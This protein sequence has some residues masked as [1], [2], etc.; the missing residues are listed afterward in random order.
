[1]TNVFDPKS[2]IKG[3]IAEEIFRI[4][5]LGSDFIV[6]D[7]GIEDIAKR[8]IEE[9]TYMQLPYH[10]LPD[11]YVLFHKEKENFDKRTEQ[12]DLNLVE[13]KYVAASYSNDKSRLIANKYE[14]LWRYR[15][16]IFDTEEL[17]DLPKGK[18]F[19]NN[20]DRN[21]ENEL[22]S[23]KNSE[24]R[25]NIKALL[26]NLIHDKNKNLQDCINEPEFL[27]YLFINDVEKEDLE[28]YRKAWLE[29]FASFYSREEQDDIIEHYSSFDDDELPHIFVF[30]PRQFCWIPIT[31][32][33][34]LSEL[35]GHN[36]ANE[37]QKVLE[38]GVIENAGRKERKGPL[39]EGMKEIF[40][41]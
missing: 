12:M 23:C 2:Q 40:G 8:Y 41:W 35:F 19:A 24:Q 32:T 5:F 30:T 18:Y 21:M 36:K 4:H 29:K 13:V 34:G 26:K 11:F 17:F 9:N 10:R 3:A 1:M 15:E 38:E 31:Y 33:K 16:H 7:F 25:N 39:Y 6:D 14:W 22:F 20:W 37:L 28:T 27:I